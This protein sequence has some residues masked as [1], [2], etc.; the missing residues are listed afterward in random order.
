MRRY[1]NVPF[2]EKDEAK[3]LGAQFDAGVKR[4][5]ILEIK[6]TEP[7]TKWIE[8]PSLRKLVNLQSH[9]EFEKKEDNSFKD[10]A[11]YERFKQWKSW[12]IANLPP[13]KY[14]DHV[15]A[16]TRIGAI[17]VPHRYEE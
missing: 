4:W 10:P 14:R 6:D 16:F 7:F 9:R 1:L 17:V 8:K 3:A 2:S 13:C 12:F 15:G 5:W 11:V